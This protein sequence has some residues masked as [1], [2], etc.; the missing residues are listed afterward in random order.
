MYMWTGDADYIENPVFLDFYKH[1][2]TDYIQRWQLQP[3]DVLSRQRIMNRRLETGKFVNSRGIPSYTEGRK[4]FSL[5]TDLLAAEY[6][7]LRWYGELLQMHGSATSAGEFDR[8]AA[9]IA[10]ILETKGWNAGEEHFNGFLRPDGQGFGP[11][12]AFTLYFNAATAP[13]QRDAALKELERET[14]EPDPG[15]EEQSYRPEIFFRYGVPEEAYNQI[16]DLSRP[17]RKRREYPEVSYAV[18][19]SMVT[20][21]MGV[22]V[23]PVDK[24][25]SR[26]LP[27]SWVVI[28]TLP[29]LSTHTSW[30]ELDN[31]PI[32][33]NVI[34]IHHVRNQSS[35]IT[36]VSGPAF[37]WRASFDGSA[38]FLRVNGKK[39][40][41]RE[42]KTEEGIA[43]AYTDISLYPGQTI[44]VSE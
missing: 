20:G 4:D 7:A 16:L 19:G 33:Q 9:G 28:Q 6:R 22:G 12:D 5:G 35:S 14:R 44:T 3:D 2:V 34:N 17:D 41:A 11:G 39:I 18:I 29:R 8:E 42:G 43:V 13:Q 23:L 27:G 21:M 32:R 37:T 10:H 1:T 36:N 40:R 24:P 25:D 30:A 31:L 26:T 15:I 38:R